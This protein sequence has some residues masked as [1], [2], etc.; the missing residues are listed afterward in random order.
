[1]HG[2]FIVYTKWHIT[3]REAM[4]LKNLIV[5]HLRPKCRIMQNTTF[6]IYDTFLR[7]QT[8]HIK[9]GEQYLHDKILCN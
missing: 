4:F 1:M 8:C 9:G 6:V 3:L 2:N 5:W 7:D